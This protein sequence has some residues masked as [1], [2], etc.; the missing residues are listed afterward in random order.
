MPFL[1]GNWQGAITASGCTSSSQSRRS[2]AQ[3]GSTILVGFC[4]VVLMTAYLPWP[5][6]AMATSPCGCTVAFEDQCCC[7]G[8]E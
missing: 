6:R 7:T 1:Q 5:S 2:E 4:G 8:Y 3:V